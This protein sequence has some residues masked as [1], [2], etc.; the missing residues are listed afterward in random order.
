MSVTRVKPEVDAAASLVKD[1]VLAPD[2]PV[3]RERPMVDVQPFW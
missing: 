2:R 3:A 1:D